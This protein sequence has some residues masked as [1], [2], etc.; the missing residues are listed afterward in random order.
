MAT[1]SVS[2][3]NPSKRKGD[4]VTVLRSK[5]GSKIKLLLFEELFLLHWIWLCVGIAAAGCLFG[6]DLLEWLYL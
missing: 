2:A 1:G 4:A 3:S 6:Q 5:D